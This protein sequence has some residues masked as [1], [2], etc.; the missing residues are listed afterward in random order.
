M[1]DS[2]GQLG[3]AACTVSSRR[4][5]DDIHDMGDASDGLLRLRP[6][7]FHYKKLWCRRSKPSNTRAD[8]FGG[9][10][11]VIPNWRS[12]S[13]RVIESVQSTLVLPPLPLNCFQK[14]HQQEQA[15][16]VEAQGRR[17]NEQA[18]TIQKLEACPPR[19]KYNLSKDREVWRSLTYTEGGR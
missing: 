18:G 17:I 13:K 14:Q 7:T 16:Q 6:V 19:L 4:Y 1:I 15:I 2:N 11:E 10:N 8:P 5:K 12:R 3:I 9:A